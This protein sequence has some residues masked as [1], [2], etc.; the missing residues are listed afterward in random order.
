MANLNSQGLTAQQM[1]QLAEKQ[2]QDRINVEAMLNPGVIKTGG[3][4]GSLP[5]GTGSVPITQQAY[6][7]K[8]SEPYKDKAIIEGS[9]T[10]PTPGA[11]NNPY[12]GKRY[13]YS[14][15]EGGYIEAPDNTYATDNTAPGY[16]NQ[17]STGAG[18][19]ATFNQTNMMDAINAI[20]SG[21]YTN[22]QKVI[23]DE[24]VR[25]GLI[26]PEQ[27]MGGTTE[28]YGTM[29]SDAAR[30]LLA[31]E[32]TDLNNLTGNTAQFFDSILKRMESRAS[33]D[34]ARFSAQSEAAQAQTAEAQAQETATAKATAFK[35]GRTGTM[36]GIDEAR[37]LAVSQRAEMEGVKM[38]YEDLIQQSRRALEDGE[39]ELAKEYR[40]A[41]QQEIQNAIDLEQLQMQKEQHAMEALKYERE[42]AGATLTD[43]VKAGYEPSEAYLS[44]MDKA[45]GWTVGTAAIMYEGTK[46]DVIREEY[47]NNLANAKTELEL[48]KLTNDLKMSVF[49]EMK[50]RNDVLAG[51]APGQFAFELN[52]KKYYGTQGTGGME[53]DENGV[54][55]IAYVDQETGDIK[56]QYVGKLGAADAQ[57]YETV[58][59][60]G[61]PIVRNTK[62]G[63]TAAGAVPSTTPGGKLDFAKYYPQGIIGT[64][65]NYQYFQCGEYMHD[66]YEDYPVGLNTWQAK[67]AAVTK[68]ASEGPAVGD[69]CF[70]KTNGDAGHVMAVNWVGQDENR[71]TIFSV[72]EANYADDGMITHDRILKASDPRILGYR[73]DTLKPQFA[74]LKSS[75]GGKEASDVD[76][77]TFNQSDVYP[78]TAGG[79]NIPT[80]SPFLAGTQSETQYQSGMAKEQTSQSFA[81]LLMS[82]SISYE[83]LRGETDGQIFAR[84]LSIA[85]AN[86][87]VQPGEKLEMPQVS[88]ADYVKARDAEM[89]ELGVI[90]SPGV[91]ALQEE[92]NIQNGLN[93]AFISAVNNQALGVTP[94]R[95]KTFRENVMEAVEQGNYTEAEDRLMTGAFRGEQV[96]MRK[97]FFGVTQINKQLDN[98]ESKL[99]AYISAGGDTGIFS[100]TLENMMQKIGTIKDPT[101]RS[102][103]AQIQ[104][105]LNDYR[106]AV[107]GAAFTESEAKLYDQMFPG[108]TKDPALNSA[109]IEGLKAGFNSKREG[110]IRNTLGNTAY[111]AIY[112]KIKV[113]DR[114]TGQIFEIPKMAYDAYLYEPVTNYNK[115]EQYIF[116]PSFITSL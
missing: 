62:T 83:D 88:F 41:A 53:I 47:E 69:I 50:K 15:V 17:I 22:D 80:A 99:N 67:Q 97:Q 60:D 19:Y 9:V 107:T 106:Y 32:T 113:Q 31:S 23:Y 24:G 89:I 44:A 57:S 34:E 5:T 35:L 64:P 110:L 43:M 100:G 94:T 10:E 2:V 52:G 103:A 30:G 68:A 21:N 25:R 111:D 75:D 101:A 13:I 71:E 73:E 92:F 90:Q 84:A 116:K 1:G 105:A 48:Q 77:K 72:T 104:V 6:A 91:A 114:E 82:D 74:N 65:R 20:K 108:I 37:Q 3:T 55:R 112:G 58:Y 115:Y 81:D 4:V 66:L 36:Y 98:V 70:Q 86:G 26:N 18:T 27:I 63:Q 87:Y 45:N 46:N 59:V 49:D 109:L 8:A 54:A 16:S 51:F 95:F 11:A 102:L 29:S 56:V 28:T 33:E 61:V 79:L 76:P 14:A 42:E 93:E 7:Y 78:Q 38:K 85:K 12:A 39:V 96:D 40:T